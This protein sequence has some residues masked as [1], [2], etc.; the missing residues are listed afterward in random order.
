MTKIPKQ[1]FTV[2]EST[3]VALE[4]CE[5]GQE[6]GEGGVLAT[7]SWPARKMK[8]LAFVAHYSAAYRH[9]NFHHIYCCIIF[10]MQGPKKYF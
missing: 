9:N 5:V 3:V 2:P 10:Y 6:G 7:S 1:I 8:L 4:L